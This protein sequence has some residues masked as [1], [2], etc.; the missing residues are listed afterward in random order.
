M[1]VYI[2]L[3]KAFNTVYHSIVMKK[4]QNIGVRWKIFDWLM[5]YLIVCQQFVVVD[6]MFSTTRVVDSGIIQSTNMGLLLFLL[7]LNDLSRSFEILNF[8]LFAEVFLLHPNHVYCMLAL[9]KKFVKLVIGLGK[10]GS[11][12]M[13]IKPAI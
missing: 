2:D 11:H 8:I 3:S 7:Y 12:S 13:S 6:R 1:A 9:M 10:M 5:T 4:L